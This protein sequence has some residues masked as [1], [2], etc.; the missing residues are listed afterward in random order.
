M[1]ALTTGL[2]LRRNAEAWTLSIDN[3][4]L[5]ALK[6][7]HVH[8][9][10]IEK[11][12]RQCLHFADST[13]VAN[14]IVLAKAPIEARPV[15]LDLLTE[16]HENGEW[17]RR[18]VA[19]SSADRHPVHPVARG[20]GDFLAR[21]AIEGYVCGV[22]ALWALYRAIVDDWS[23]ASVGADDALREFT[24]RFAS[25]R[26]RENLVVLEELLDSALAEAS[27]S[28][29]AAAAAI[30]EQVAQYTLD[31]WTMSLEPEAV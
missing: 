7:G 22:T 5:E 21:Q 24:D 6:G 31:F 8:P 17:L 16:A 1:E 12:L 23:A 27:P 14:A 19:G 13:F 29:R 26:R 4:F 2:L 20:Y 15:L 3:P 30:V 10:V 18:L 9:E 25:G 28:Q 11:F